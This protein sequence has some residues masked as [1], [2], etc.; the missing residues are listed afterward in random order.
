MADTITER[1]CRLA[2][3]PVFADFGAGDLYPL[4]AVLQPLQATSG[5][6]LMHQGQRADFFLIIET[7]EARVHHEDL[8]GGTTNIE[9]PAGSVI[10]EIALLR[11]L[12]AATN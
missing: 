11:Q 7:G 10:G 6:T 8:D 1:A 2:D 5:E 4:A 12:A 3:L 9:V